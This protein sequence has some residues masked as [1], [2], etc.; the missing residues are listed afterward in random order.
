[1]HSV[2]QH[3]RD[4]RPRL[5][6][7]AATQ[8]ARGEG[9]RALA[10]EQIER[11]YSLL[12]E[13]I[14]SGSS[15]WLDPCLQDW[16]NARSQS[17]FGERLTLLP[18]IDKLKSVAW[19]TVREDCP[20]E[21]ALEIILAMEPYFVHAQSWVGALEIEAILRESAGKVDEVQGTLRRLEK[22]K[23]D[24]IAVA[25]HELKTPLTLI[26]GYADMLADES[27]PTG[28]SQ[29][30]FLLSGITKGIARLREIVDDLVDAS[31]ID[32]DLLSLSFQPVRLRKVIQRIREEIAV[33]LAERRLTFDMSD[34]VE[35]DVITAD[36]QRMLQ[37]LRHLVLNAVKYTP[38]GGRVTVSAHA[39]PGFVELLI[40]DTGIGIAIENQQRIFERF[41]P[42]NDVALHST[43][44]TRFKGGGTGLGLA[45]A[46]GVIEAHGGS[47]WCES[48]GY[49]EEACPGSTFHLM[50]PIMPPGPEAAFA[51]EAMRDLV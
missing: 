25:A 31:M 39:R 17:S 10:A 51:A 3:L 45:I 24:F 35:D 16:V 9:L 34:F 12:E 1:M 4:L 14:D 40:A 20:P 47:I 15:E 19:Q 18:V 23:S 46:R 30:S 5:I 38:D 2:A 36:P 8:L 11:F 28:N 29:E 27:K 32:N 50:I 33:S 21:A 49:D 44:K 37:I 22:S 26:E 43:S 6:E 41:A 7:H 48:P 13:A 42:I